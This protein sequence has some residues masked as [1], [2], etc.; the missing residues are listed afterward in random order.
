MQIIENNSPLTW[1]D[2]RYKKFYQ[3]VAQLVEEIQAGLRGKDGKTV[4]RLGEAGLPNL[5]Y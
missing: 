5:T 3:I 1:R 4:R 2:K